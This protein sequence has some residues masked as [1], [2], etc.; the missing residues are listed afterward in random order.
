VREQIY[1]ES[2]IDGHA[3]QVAF[4]ILASSF[5]LYIYYATGSYLNPDEAIHVVLANRES[6]YGAYEASHSIAHPPLMIIV[7]HFLLKLGKSVFILRLLSAV[8]SIA[9]LWFVFKWIQRAFGSVEG[10]VGLMLLS[11]SPGMISIACEVRQY[12][13][14]LFFI[15]GAL[16][17][18]QR[19][20]DEGSLWAGFV[21]SLFLYGAILTHYSAIW[22][23]LTFTIYVTTVFF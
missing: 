15:S 12:A 14:L 6:V 2:W 21:S 20:V 5:F 7:L 11:F 10:I 18:V 3:N 17:F 13:M 23:A 9:A 22:V 19:F 16:Y 8:L 1:L 4:C